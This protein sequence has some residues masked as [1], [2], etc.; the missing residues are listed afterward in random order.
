MK[1]INYTYPYIRQILVLLIWGIMWVLNFFITPTYWLL[2]VTNKIRKNKTPILVWFIN[3]DEPTDVENNYGDDAYRKERGIYDIENMGFF[4]RLHRHFIWCVMRNSFYHFK[5][6]VLIPKPIE[7]TIVK[8][9]KNT[10]FGEDAN[11]RQNLYMADYE[12]RGVIHVLEERDSSYYFRFSMT[13]KFL[14]GRLINIQ[15]GAFDIKDIWGND[16]DS[17]F[18]YKLRFPK[19]I[20]T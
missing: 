14:F 17:R 1:L 19:Q 12:D 3:D 16:R 11:Y 7:P 4:K 2:G 9:Y 20:K 13:K 10:I 8:V 15:L 6:N 18:V 5:L